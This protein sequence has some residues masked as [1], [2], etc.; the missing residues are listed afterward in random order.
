MDKRDYYETLEVDRSIDSVSLKKAY[1]RLAMQFHPDRNPGDSEAE[2]RF[3]EVSE[4]YDILKDDQ[5]R[6]AYD[7]FGHQ[8]FEN[9]GGP[10]AGAGGFDF[11]SNFSDVFDDLFGDFMGG[12][13]RRPSAA[14]RGADLRYNLEIDLEEAF[15]GSEAA[16]EVT[17]TKAC[18]ECT[19]SGAEKGSQPEACPTCGGTGK[20]R[21]QQ[22]FFMVERTCAR[23]HGGGHIIANP[24]HVCR[25]A[26]R[27]ERER[28]LSVKI[29]AGVEDGTRIRLSGEGDAGV[30]GG[31][32]GDL[33]IFVSIRPHPIYKRHNTSLFCPVDISMTTAALGG[34]I[35]IE[36]L[37]GKSAEIKI[38]EGTQSGQR[39][40]LK[41]KGMP[42]L[43]AGFVG[44][45]VVEAR[46]KIPTGL[47]RK[48]K[49]LMRQFAN[50]QDQS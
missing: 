32:P 44:N 24:C 5:K 25:G 9:G 8:A 42:Q 47:T 35:T 30:R 33:Y 38:P 27:V 7:R 21:T 3:K 19:G 46:V 11:N 40:T 15:A 50:E 17:S 14:Q 43:N 37:D 2:T 41:R 20:Q 31:P 45:L 16:I 1:R 12:T 6:A 34:K 10:R 36:T 39:F 28:S 18:G 22:G 29:P 13:R 23:C 4:A 26:G 48:E 49:E